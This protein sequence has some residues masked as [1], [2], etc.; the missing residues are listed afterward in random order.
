MPANPRPWR[1]V[2]VARLDDAKLVSKLSPLLGMEEV[3]AL[4]V[5]R[6]KPVPLA[7][8]VNHN[9]PILLRRLGPLAELWRLA[10]V[11]ALGL[12]YRGSAVMVG[13]FLVPHGLFVELAR[14]LLGV[15]TIQVLIGEEDLVRALGSRFFLESVRRARAVGVR[16]TRTASRLAESRVA[17]DRLFSPP[18]V[19]DPAPYRPDPA[20]AP[21]IDVV[22]VGT[23][24]PCK[25][26]DVLLDA[27]ARVRDRRGHVRA[28][29]VGE[30]D[31]RRA[32]EAQCAALG[33]EGSVTFAGPQ[34][35]EGVAAW[36]RRSRIFAL[37]SELEGLPMAM[38]EAMTC[39]LPVLVTD[40]G[41]VTSVARH[42]ENAWVVARPEVESVAAGLVRLLTDDVLR[43]RLAAGARRSAAQFA[44][45]SSLEAARSE[46]RRALG[47][48][49]A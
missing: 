14:R 33:L 27:L 46:W 41:D 39:G 15:P 36:L 25:R 24:V 12:R 34:P 21:D 30:G 48:R 29:L 49:A 20:V 18:N 42:D 32:L 11:L 23:L 26:I 1:V 3:A 2:V 28:V 16:G 19:F 8:V 37:T 35:A 4:H 17:A 47:H 22:F 44:A 7:G 38:I 6:R 43:E 10:A 13:I 5:V 9:P 40:V 45:A 31:R